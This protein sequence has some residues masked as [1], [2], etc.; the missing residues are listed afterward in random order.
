MTKRTSRQLCTVETCNEFV[1]AE[2][3]LLRVLSFGHKFADV[4][5]DQSR[6]FRV[7]TNTVRLA[8]RN[9]NG[10]IYIGFSYRQPY[11]I[12]SYSLD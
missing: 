11:F 12:Y 4:N 5:P 3:G 10:L 6:F 8:A 1:R 7:V 9:P 2:K